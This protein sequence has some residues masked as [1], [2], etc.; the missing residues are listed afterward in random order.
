M[1]TTRPPG[2]GLGRHNDFGPAR[3]QTRIDPLATHIV[4]AFASGGVAQ[5]ARHRRGVTVMP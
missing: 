5:P 1:R 4:A 2:P 3:P